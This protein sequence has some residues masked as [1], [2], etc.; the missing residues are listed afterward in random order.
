MPLR[1]GIDLVAVS[2][3]AES[4][5]A[6][7]DRYV[8]RVCT[9]REARACRGPSGTDP[10]RMAELLAAKEAAMKVL[11][12]GPGT[13]LPW[14]DVE[15]LPGAGGGHTL[16]LGGTAARLAARLGLGDLEVSVSREGTHAAAVAVAGFPA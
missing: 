16:E 15:V 11:R 10:G 7:G 13:P 9:P 3:V 5:A 6:H 4:L 1:A 12:P 14:T 2:S 8:D